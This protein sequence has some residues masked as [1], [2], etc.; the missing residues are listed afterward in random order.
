M[1]RERFKQEAALVVLK[2]LMGSVADQVSAHFKETKA[3]D[4]PKAL[5]QWEDVRARVIAGVVEAIADAT[6]QALGP[7]QLPRSDR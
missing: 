2:A 6:T 1:S 5:C 7:D 3:K 4:L